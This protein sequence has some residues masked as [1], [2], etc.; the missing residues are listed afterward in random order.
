M[1]KILFTLIIAIIAVLNSQSQQ[2]AISKLK[3]YTLREA[4]ELQKTQPKKILIDIY[5]DWCGWCKKMDRDVFSHPVIARYLNENYYSVKFN[6]ESTAPIDFNGQKF[7]N[8]NS[9]PRS[10]H[11]FAI[12][13]L[14]GQM[15]YPSISY[16]T[17]K[18]EYLGAMP[19]YKSPEQLEVILNF[20]G[21]D[22]YKTTTLEEF[23]KTF[24]GNIKAPAGN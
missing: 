2:V 14:K 16:F 8:E 23:E 5:T 10:S 15:S 3:W 19:G 1:K 22:K 24:V 18:L 13:L 12:A 21:Q 9:G 6:A 7:I 4:L 11:Q 17:E 20:I